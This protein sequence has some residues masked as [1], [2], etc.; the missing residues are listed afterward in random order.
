MSDPASFQFADQWY[1]LAPPWL[2]TG[3]A[4]KYMFPLQFA[5]DLLMEKTNQAIKIRLP[6]Q[7]DAS[8]IP[9][10]AHDRALVQGPSEPNSSFL[11]RLTGASKAWGIAGSR[12]AVLQQLHYYLQGLNPGVTAGNPEVAIVGGG[13][14]ATVWDSVFISDAMGSVPARTTVQP[15]NFNWD[16]YAL[17]WLTFLVLYMATVPTGLSGASAQTSTAIA[18]SYALPGQN[19]GGVWVP[20]TSGTPVN[21][22]WLTITGLTGLSS[23]QVGQWLSLS[24]SSHSGN[25]GAFQIVQVFSAT[26]CLIANPAGVTADSGPL[27]WSIADYPFLAPGPVWG[28]TFFSFGFGQLSTP[29]IDTGS[30]VGGVWQ[31]TTVGTPGKLAWGLRDNSVAPGGVSPTFVLQSLRQIVQTWKSAPTWY[32]QIVVS[33]AGGSGAAG[34]EYSPMSSQGAG[35][36]SG[37][38]GGHGRNINGVWVPNGRLSSLYDCYCQGTGLWS[39]C[40]VQNIT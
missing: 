36:P 13:P 37:S 12:V 5:E 26:S 22:P 8:Q 31:P 2:R 16:G 10:L 35:N 33:F 29:P 17:P 40:S 15:I 24:G 23:A 1:S 3:M 30:N 6:G 27:A 38:S 19:V 21:Y 25:N 18:G 7:G 34:Y 14:G 4:E 28:R 39:S 9:Y 11:G 20:A 32:A